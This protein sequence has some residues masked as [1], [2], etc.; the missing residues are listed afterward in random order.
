MW[1]KLSLDLLCP[2]STARKICNILW[3]EPKRKPD[4]L[5]FKETFIQECI[6]GGNKLK[7]KESH[8]LEILFKESVFEDSVSFSRFCYGVGWFGPLNEKC[9]PFFQRMKEIYSSPFFHGFLTESQSNTKL[10]DAFEASSDRKSYY[11][12]KYSMES[13]GEFI[14]CYYNTDAS[15]VDS[16]VIRNINGKLKI[17]NGEIYD[18]WKKLKSGVS[19]YF[20][21]G[22]HIPRIL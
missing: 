5:T 9:G 1:D 7:E 15:R 18:N 14:L 11:L 8:M 19:K 12:V 3:K 20:N 17:E 4:Y 22:K 6:P 16:I 13:I 2:D 21:I 10:Q